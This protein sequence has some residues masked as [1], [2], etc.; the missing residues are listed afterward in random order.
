MSRR[1]AQLLC[2]YGTNSFKG[3]EHPQ[4]LIFGG[5]GGVR[6]VEPARPG[7]GQELIVRAGREVSGQGSGF[8]LALP[9]A[10][11]SEPPCAG[12]SGLH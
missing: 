5:W 7:W 2:K 11:R 10:C 9:K 4:M 3:L 12:F 8:S 6:V 1:M